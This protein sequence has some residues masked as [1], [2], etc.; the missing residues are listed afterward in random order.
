MDESESRESRQLDLV[1]RVGESEAKDQ[2]S[3][4]YKSI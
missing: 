4:E 1:G 3:E 2:S